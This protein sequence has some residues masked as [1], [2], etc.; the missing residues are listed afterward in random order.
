MA[1]SPLSPR[2]GLEPS[3]AHFGLTLPDPALSGRI[4]SYCRVLWRENESLNLTR[5][6]DFDTF[7]ARDLNDV[8]QLSRLIG[9]G[10]RVLD[11]GSGG[12]VPGLLLQL[13]RPDLAVTLCES[14]AKK[15]R[16][17]ERMIAALQLQCGLRH[18]RAEALLASE[19]FD[20]G[21]A[22]AVG[23]LWKIC[24]WLHGHWHA[25]GRLL[26]LKG[27]RWT[28]E[29][30]EA[31]RHTLSAEVEIKLALEY[32]MLGTDSKAYILKLWAKG[33]PEPQ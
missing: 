21:A 23:P 32:P 19:R 15:A 10:E 4:E 11:I 8:L 27:S 3:L 5:H 16:S 13:V 25:L 12:G 7:V 29:V 17:L 30:A 26:A 2:G 9:P 14:M 6:L 24:Q 1:D 31:R 20:V 18:Q 28:E 33:M 22:R